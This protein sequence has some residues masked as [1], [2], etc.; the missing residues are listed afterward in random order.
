[1]TEKRRILITKKKLVRILTAALLGTTIFASTA[2]AASGTSPMTITTE[3]IIAQS[4]LFVF[5]LQLPPFFPRSVIEFFPEKIKSAPTEISAQKRKFP[6][7]P[8]KPYVKWV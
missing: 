8:N 7:S 3:S 5:I 6:S 4:R 1:M 2:F